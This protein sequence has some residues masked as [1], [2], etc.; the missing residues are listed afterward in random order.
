MV[1]PIVR[2]VFFVIVQVVASSCRLLPIPENNFQ[3]LLKLPPG[4]VNFLIKGNVNSDFLQT[5]YKDLI[6]P[7][8][9]AIIAEDITLK[10]KNGD[11]KPFQD[12][13]YRTILFAYK[14]IKDLSDDLPFLINYLLKESSWDSRT[15]FIIA[16]EFSPPMQPEIQHEVFHKLHANGIFNAVLLTPRTNSAISQLF[17]KSLFG[18]S[19]HVHNKPIVFDA[20]MAKASFNLNKM[21]VKF[22]I[23]HHHSEL[24]KIFMDAF[25]KRFNATK[26]MI[27]V[28]FDQ[29]S[30]WTQVT[31]EPSISFITKLFPINYSNKLNL[32]NHPNLKLDY[33]SGPDTEECV[34][35][36][37]RAETSI[38]VL[39]IIG[40]LNCIVMIIIFFAVNFAYYV[41]NRKYKVPLSKL[42][43]NTLPLC[44]LQ[45]AH[46]E[47]NRRKQ[48]VAVGP[49]LCL[50]FFLGRILNVNF[51]AH[52]IKPDGQ[53]TVR[54]VNDLITQNIS[55]FA[56]TSLELIVEYAL[57][58]D[59][60]KYVNWFNST[61]RELVLAEPNAAIFY[62]LRK[63][64]LTKDFKLSFGGNIYQV[65]RV[66]M[67]SSPMVMVYA[68]HSPY[69]HDGR[70]IYL[71]NIE[72]GLY[73]HIA[74]K[75]GRKEKLYLQREL[76]LN[77]KSVSL[78]NDQMGAALG[79]F[80]KGL[81][82]SIIGFLAE[83]LY[84]KGAQ[85][86]LVKRRRKRLLNKILG[87]YRNTI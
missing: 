32:G 44:L 68:R 56:P 87:K 67:P 70:F 74:K 13:V 25:I 76:E 59:L 4:T 65:I 52:L 8:E 37:V 19:V 35:I 23:G 61:L 12:Q 5:V 57:R 47:L 18:K 43:I 20:K 39:R 6:S 54:T 26:W 34:V 1:R 48:R 28:D 82:S 50:F 17:S 58:E 63:T 40:D 78:Q 84:Y 15:M 79:I 72:S 81:L 66:D 62:S 42:I 9:H 49:V 55:L 14:E 7:Q 69:A 27:P 77:H 16:M 64:D 41:C 71:R 83:L 29:N 36:L 22:F 60:L 86:Y 85:W 75:I 24:T 2:I 80:W 21:A 31:S 46:L 45:S 73:L 38:S 11:R 51:V 3:F 53:S 30:T 33:A 10:L